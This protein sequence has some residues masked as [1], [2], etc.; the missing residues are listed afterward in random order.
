MTMLATVRTISS[1]VRSLSALLLP[2]VLGIGVVLLFHPARSNADW[3]VMTDGSQ[4][5]TRGA[6]KVDGSRILF[7][8]PN[9]LLVSIRTS[10]VDLDTSEQRSAEAKSAKELRSK[11]EPKEPRKAVM[12]LTDADV[13]HPKSSRA[14]SDSE[15]P[16]SSPDSTALSDDVVVT[17]W[18]TSDTPDKDGIRI[19]GNVR[20]S[21]SVVAADLNIEIAAYDS[22]DDLL[23]SVPASLGAR[24]LGPGQSTSL[25]AELRGVFSYSR[26]EFDIDYLRL[27]SRAEVEP[28]TSTRRPDNR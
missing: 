25:A 4:V 13:G 11:P 5:E 20:N 14:K 1:Q 23:I 8:T 3:L 15:S 21:S 18:N 2:P 27:A 16:G 17:S 22:T 7:E 9:G 24:A 6:W 19:V 28:A 12:V 26:V 10:E